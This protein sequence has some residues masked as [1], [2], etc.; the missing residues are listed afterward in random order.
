MRATTSGQRMTEQP[1]RCGTCQQPT[2]E[3]WCCPACH[4]ALCPACEA[5]EHSIPAGNRAGSP[6]PAKAEPEAA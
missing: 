1:Y 4:N 3:V 6:C 5:E 2:P